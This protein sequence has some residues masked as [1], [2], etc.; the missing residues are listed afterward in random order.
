[1]VIKAVK[2]VLKA[3]LL[4]GV[5]VTMEPEQP[6]VPGTRV[7]PGPVTVKAAAGNGRQLMG[8][9]K[10]A[11]STWLTGTP[12]ALFTGIVD[13]TTGIGVIVVNVQT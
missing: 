10:T 3:R 9:L 1:V 7:R 6:M 11:L 12:V 13:N 5:N 2:T 4:A 8:S